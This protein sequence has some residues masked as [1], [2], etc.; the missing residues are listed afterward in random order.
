[1]SA[2]VTTEPKGGFF[3]TARVHH[4]SDDLDRVERRHARPPDDRDGWATGSHA[5]DMCGDRLVWEAEQL[6]CPNGCD[7]DDLDEDGDR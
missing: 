6:V 4:H 5:C 3:V 1:M 7:I 2:T